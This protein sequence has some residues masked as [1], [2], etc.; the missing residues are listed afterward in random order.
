MA[1]KQYFQESE[2][3]FV[4][5]SKDW[6][7]K[8][9]EGSRF[10]SLLILGFAGRN[11]CKQ[12]QWFCKCD[13]GKII[14][15]TTNH[16]TTKHTNSCG[17]FL[18][19]QIKKSNTTHGKTVG[20]KVPDVYAIWVGMN[21]RCKN[22]NHKYYKD[23]GARGISVCESWQNSFE[24]FTTDMGE[25]PE[26]LTL[27]RIENDLGYFKENCRWATRIEQGNNKRNNRVITFNGETKTIA[28]WANI[29]LVS[30]NILR[31]RINRG[32]PIEKALTLP[33]GQTLTKY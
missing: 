2:L 30:D 21:Q 15:V 19:E 13:C 12:N 11:K 18:V 20:L 25:R 3:V 32:W 28:Q 16:L 24:N 6:R 26:G 22:P 10:H 7:F 23:Y 29:A 4:E 8:D 1:K 33:I 17:C 27:E 14:R 9:L 5:K 31:G